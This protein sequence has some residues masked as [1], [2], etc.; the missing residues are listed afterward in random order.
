MRTGLV[1]AAA[2]LCTARADA[3]TTAK[4]AELACH[5]IERLAVLKKID[6]RFVDA[7]AGLDVA[8]T[9]QPAGFAVSGLR[10]ADPGAAAG[11][12]DLVL[13]SAGKAVSFTLAAGQDASHP[14]AWPDKDPLT[15]AE[16][17]LHFLEDQAVG[18][19]ALS[20]FSTALSS[21][22]VRMRSAGGPNPSAE[23]EMRSSASGAVLLVRLG[24]DGVYASHEVVPATLPTY[25]S[26]RETVFER[27]CVACHSKGGKAEDVPLEPLADL[28]AS[29]RDLVLPG[30]PD[31]SGLVIAVERGD[32]KRMPPASGGEALTGEQVRAIRAWIQAGAK[33]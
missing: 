17:S 33:G 1:A 18:E 16:N 24:L 7:F 22:R 20:A 25:D 10:E 4:A 27:R 8:P 13:D 15:I 31:E 26:I 5:R 3:T 11:R 32:K 28:L 9:L 2:A 30:N 19:A 29:P 14:A 23:V 12:I 6:P 21:M